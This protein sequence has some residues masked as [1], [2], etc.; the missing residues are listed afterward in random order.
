MGLAELQQEAMDAIYDGDDLER[1][2]VGPFESRKRALM[3]VVA[4]AYKRGWDECEETV[5]EVVAIA[6]LGSK[7]PDGRA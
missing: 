2:L 6:T 7:Q 5:A 3:R 1:A 4:G